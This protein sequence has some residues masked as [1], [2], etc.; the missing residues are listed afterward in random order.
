MAEKVFMFDGQ[1]AFTPGV[2]RALFDKYP[3]AAEIIKETSRIL[4]HD[5]T[6]FLWGEKA[7]QTSKQTSIAQPLIS[8][9]SLAY[10]EV[11]KDLG[12]KGNVSLGHSLGE[13]TAMIYCGVVSFEDGIRLIQKRG[14]LMEKGGKQGTMMAIINIDIKSLE[15]MC[16]TA[17]HDVAEPVVV[18]NINAPNQIVISGSQDSV[19]RVAQMV[20][21]N[22]GRAIPLIVGGAWHSP[23]LKD[24]AIEFAEFLDSIKFTK[25]FL[26]FYSVVDQKILSDPEAIK[27]ALKHQMLAQVNWVEAIKNLAALGFKKFVEIGPSKILKDLVIKIEPKVKTESTALFTDLGELVKNF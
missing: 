22:H 9:V 8:A 3:K 26:K 15:A 27:D 10:A 4:D 13:V 6:Q 7:H 18:A 19:K 11:L 5:I 20:T 2:G 17:A 14:A 21:Q 25:T 23:Y 24:V 12:M 1:G 16:E